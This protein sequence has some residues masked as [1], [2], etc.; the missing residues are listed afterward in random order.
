M[1][2][3][4]NFI[5]FGLYSFLK[6]KTKLDLNNLEDNK[7]FLDDKQK[8]NNFCQELMD[9]VNK[10][11][12]LLK[13][14]EELSKK[15]EDL[16]KFELLTAD[17][18]KK[19][20]KLLLDYQSI[21]EEKESLKGR[22]ISRNRI[23]SV[24]QKYENKFPQIL[25]EIKEAEEKQLRVKR[26]IDYLEGEKEALI[27]SREQLENAQIILYRASIGVSIIFGIIAIIFAIIIVNTNISIFIPASIT[28]ALCGIIGTWIY[29]F[30]RKVEYEIKKNGRM[31]SRAIKLLN[32]AKIRYVYYTSFLEYEYKKF[33]V[34]SVEQLERSWELYNKNKHHEKR[35]RNINSTMSKIEEKVMEILEKRG[36]HIDF[37]DDI[38]RWNKIE[39]RRKILMDIRKEKKEIEEKLDLLDTYQED[40]WK[41]LT[42]LK[43][44]DKTQDKIIEKIIQNYLES[45]ELK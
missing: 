42:E 2:K 3:F 43:E 27:Y 44:Q 36:I 6:K 39:E 31:Q 21:I 19:I 45:I 5:T 37:F 28:G 8:A 16:E 34:D 4:L 24:V 33:K 11:I 30:R 12:N 22:L 35:Y 38:N 26:D 1:N 41:Q 20:R 23:L 7:E 10:K 9:I 40:I 14:L 17:D 25:Y 13:E 15:E 29:V 18:I 32:K